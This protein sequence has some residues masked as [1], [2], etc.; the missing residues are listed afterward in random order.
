MRVMK[1]RGSQRTN[2]AV[3]NNVSVHLPVLVTTAIAAKE[4]DLM[5]GPVTT[6][7]K[8]P[9]KDNI[10]SRDPE[11]L[12]PPRF[13]HSACDFLLQLLSHDF[14]CIHDH[15]PLALGLRYRPVLLTGRILIR[16]LE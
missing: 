10:L 13:R 1:I 2:G 15:D 7:T 8:P 3:D 9:V 16:M 14:I 4:T 6:V 11:C 5:V 12:K